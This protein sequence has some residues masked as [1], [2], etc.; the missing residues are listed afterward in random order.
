MARKGNVLNGWLVIDKP[1]GVTSTDVVRLLKRTL[2]PAKI[3][4]AGTLDPLATGI[5]P[6]A[7]G[8]ATKTIPFLMESTKDYAFTVRFGEERATDDIEG[9]VTATSAKRPTRDGILKALPAFTGIISQ[10]PPQYSA[11]KVKGQRAYQLARAGEA[12]VLKERPAEVKSFELTAVSPDG[13]RADFRVTCASGTYI[14]ALG[15]DLGRAL[16]CLGCIEAIRRTRVGPFSENHAISL[17]NQGLLGH[18]A[19]ALEALLP[20]ITAL[21]DIP[22]LAVTEGEAARI[23]CGEALRL[24]T[25]RSGTVR[26]TSQGELVAL[27]EVSAGTAKPKRVFNL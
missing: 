22:A 7:L 5:L 15:R 12:V 9:E 8:E 11:V 6:I 21:D 10:V 26:I 17:D 20:V 2:H 23:R 1:A 19:P 24:P 16:G 3:G 18:S 13:E 25:A 4:H 14:R 27:A